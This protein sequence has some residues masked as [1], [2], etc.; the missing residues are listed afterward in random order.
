M[1]MNVRTDCISY[2]Q[3]VIFK[4]KISDLT[5]PTTNTE[6]ISI[7]IREKPNEREELFH[8]LCDFATKSMMKSLGNFTS[9]SEENDT[10]K[11]P[12]TNSTTN[13]S[14]SR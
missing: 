5:T 6:N 12:D 11:W 13:V 7:S 14:S 3:N 8:N 9:D 2:L 1:N 10:L 4:D